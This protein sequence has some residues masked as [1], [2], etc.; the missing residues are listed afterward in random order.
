VPLPRSLACFNRVVTN[1]VAGARL[2][3]DPERR[4]VPAPVR[5]VLRLVGVD[6]FLELEETERPPGS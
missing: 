6:H 1:R 3:R 5:P 4:P 2:V